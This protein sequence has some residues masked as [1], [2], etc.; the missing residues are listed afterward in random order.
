MCLSTKWY[1]TLPQ[2]VPERPG[3]DVLTV[4]VSV[5]YSTPAARA[6]PMEYR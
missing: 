4:E 2:A 6:R 5:N 1:K 3:E